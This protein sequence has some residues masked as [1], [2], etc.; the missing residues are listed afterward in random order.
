MLVSVIA[1]VTRAYLDLRALQMQLGVVRKNIEVARAL[2]GISCRSASIA[3]SPTSPM[4]RWRDA[5]WR[6]CRRRWRRSSARIDAARY[7]IAALIGEFPENLGK[8]WR[9][10]H[11][12]ASF[13]AASGPACR[14]TFCAGDRYC[15]SRA[16]L[17][18]ATA[19][20]AS[21]PPIYF[22]RWR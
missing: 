10:G 4:S 1:D 20:S 18:K 19:L 8:D 5:N 22:P 2:H 3:A 16:Q 12:A 7:V 11:A 21:P 6:D 13:R 9:T 14:L 17:A 15:R